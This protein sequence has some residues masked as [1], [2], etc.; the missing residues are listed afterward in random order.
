MGTYIPCVLILIPILPLLTACTAQTQMN[1]FIDRIPNPVVPI[2]FEDFEN[3]LGK[4]NQTS[5]AW[6]TATPA[7]TG[8][9]L[10][11]PASTSPAT[12]TI[13]T[14][15]T[16]D[17]SG[18]TGC[19][20][21]Y[22]L[23]YDLTGASGV[24]AQ[25]QFAGQTVASLKESTGLYA[26]NS[27]SQFVSRKVQLISSM[28]K[29]SV[30]TTLGTSTVADLRLDNIVIRCGNPLGPAVTLVSEN[31]QSG[32]TNWTLGTNWGLA[33]GLGQE[34]STGLR[35]NCSDC[36]GAYYTSYTPTFSLLNRSGCRI[37]YYFDM[38]GNNN[39][40]QNSLTLFVNSV[41]YVVHTVAGAT[42]FGDYALTAFE[43]QMGNQFNFRGFEGALGTNNILIIDNVTVTC[44]Q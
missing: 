7:S 16:F 23:A 10:K 9:A 28:G 12:Y 13:T 30:V 38:T 44:Q 26:P 29:L 15:D 24:A 31:F 4:W 27:A 25:I 41:Q 37:Q 20:L 3:G 6:T 39:A 33:T 35:F 5:G 42:G 40:S 11:S 21:S 17:L 32:S 2:F 36:N 43:G 22:E 8:L 34:G 1:E 19:I 18:K 14:V